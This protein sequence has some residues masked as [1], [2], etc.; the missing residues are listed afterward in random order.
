MERLSGAL[1][2]TLLKSASMEFVVCFTRLF[3]PAVAGFDQ[4]FDHRCD[5]R[6]RA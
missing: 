1:V 2:D 3:L 6:I 4:L 5:K